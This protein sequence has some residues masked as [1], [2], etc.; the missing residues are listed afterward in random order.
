MGNAISDAFWNPGGDIHESRG[1]GERNSVKWGEH[2]CPEIQFIQREHKLLI[3]S[4]GLLMRMGSSVASSSSFK[5]KFIKIS[6]NLNVDS[7]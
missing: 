2:T 3:T 4:P 7:Y 1:S 5:E 6:P